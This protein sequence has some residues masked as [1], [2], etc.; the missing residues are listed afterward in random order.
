[1]SNTDGIYAIQTV[2]GDSDLKYGGL[3]WRRTP[4]GN[5]QGNGDGPGLWNGISLPLFDI[6]QEKDFG[7]KIQTPISKTAL[8][9]T[10]FGF[11]D[12]TD[13]IQTI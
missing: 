4:H 11:V 1:M 5:G 3:S 9:Y 13:L 7:M 10:G 12:D 8:H 2:F 6:V